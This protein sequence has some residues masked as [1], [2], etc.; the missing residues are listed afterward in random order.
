MDQ[1]YEEIKHFITVM[2]MFN[3]DMAQNWD[4]LQTAF[5]EADEVWGEQGDKTRR[6][7]QNRWQ[8]LGME[9]HNYRTKHSE[10]YLMFLMR[11]KQAL[12]EYFGY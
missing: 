1:L 10:E 8:Q 7:F 11:R 9:L 5:H 12:D 2:T 3:N 6:E 4:S